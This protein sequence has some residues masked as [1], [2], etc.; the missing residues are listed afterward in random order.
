MI[1][2]VEN[3]FP[4]AISVDLTV[5]AV[6][7][8]GSG[9]ASFCI[10]DGRLK[11]VHVNWPGGVGVSADNVYAVKLT[12]A[13]K[14]AADDT[15]LKTVTRQHLINTAVIAQASGITVDGNLGDWSGVTP[16]SLGSDQANQFSATS[17]NP[18][19]SGTVKAKVY[20]AWDADYVYVAAD[21][22]EGNYGC[23]ARTGTTT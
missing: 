14:M 8:S 13:C 23:S 17:V 3:Q 6:G 15:P 22:T 4:H 9:T 12:A 20:T 1:V 18:G 19:F 5:E 2:R 21:V 7:G 11:E 10:P 16:V